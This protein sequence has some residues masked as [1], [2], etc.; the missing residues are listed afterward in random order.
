VHFGE[1]PLRQWFSLRGW[2]GLSLGGWSTAVLGFYYIGVEWLGVCSAADGDTCQS[3]WLFNR[4]V[5]SAWK[6]LYHWPAY[7]WC[8]LL[9][10]GV[11]RSFCMAPCWTT[12]SCLVVAEN[13][14]STNLRVACGGQQ[15]TETP[16]IYLLLFCS[17][18]ERKLFWGQRAEGKNQRNWM[19]RI[20]TGF[21]TC[22]YISSRPESHTCHS[23]G[24]N[25]RFMQSK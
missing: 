5:P 11:L 21:R 4:G 19:L 18:Q 8:N 24:L 20:A 7:A 3:S 15:I 13:E 1:M 23:N 9:L 17:K 6:G 10:S 25:N 22:E 2:M 16:L 14:L 12:L